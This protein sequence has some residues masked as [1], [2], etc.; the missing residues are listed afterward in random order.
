MSWAIHNLLNKAPKSNDQNG[1][2][3]WWADVLTWE[4][5]VTQ[6]LGNRA[7]FTRADELH[8]GVLGFVD[9]SMWTSGNVDLDSK[10]R[11]L[12]MKFERLRDIINWTQMRRR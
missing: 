2:D 1:I 11:Q 5:K 7:F 4:A 6:A 10:L 12:K 9:P 3:Q 8:F